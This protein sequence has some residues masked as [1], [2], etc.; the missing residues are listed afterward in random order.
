MAGRGARAGEGTRSA[1]RTSLAKPKVWIPLLLVIVLIGAGSFWMVR[2]NS[3]TTSAATTIQTA[4]VSK[5]T[6]Q[7][8]VAASGTFAPKVTKTLSF[9]VSGTVTSV[10]VKVGDS[11]KVGETLA[12]V[13]DSALRQ[14]L[15]I[16]RANLTAASSS[17]STA[18]SSSSTTTAQLATARAQYYSASAKVT[19]AEDDLDA[20]SLTSPIAGTVAAV[21]VAVGDRVG[22]GSSGTGGSS[23]STGATGS[24]TG[25]T[26]TSSGAVTVVTP[27]QWTVTTSINGADIASIKKGLQAQITPTGSSTLVFGVVSSVGVI[28]TTSGGTATF[29]VTIDVTGSPKGIY[30]GGTNTVSIIVKQL[31]DILT[32]PTA[33]L[34]VSNGTTT[35]QKLVNGTAETTTVK[36]GETFGTVTQI[37][38]GLSEGDEITYAGHGFGGGAGSGSTRSS[39]SGGGIGIP[40]VGIGGGR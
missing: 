21:N 25:S 36:I 35:V 12:T 29:P 31:T 27:T 34:S 10:P 16:A 8:T 32:V 37:T 3:Q 5:S 19:Q 14:A 7:T 40:G 24:T 28:G 30:I 9:T 15:T 2:R 17:L 39:G 4:T 11:V 1:V 6:Q 26:V 38:D 22:S 13:G 18:R 33:A 23:G 20:A